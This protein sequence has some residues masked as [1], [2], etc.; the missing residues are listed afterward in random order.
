MQEYMI[1]RLAAVGFKPGDEIHDS[2]ETLPASDLLD[3][4]E[5]E[6]YERGVRKELGSGS[7]SDEVVGERLSRLALLRYKQG[8]LSKHGLLLS[9]A[10]S[11]KR[12]AVGRIA[13]AAES[14]H[15]DI[16]T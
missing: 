11:R 5:G 1:R 13:K 15:K 12:A 14:K 10:N 16:V 3:E 7:A 2:F 6:V 8:K 9:T 4:H